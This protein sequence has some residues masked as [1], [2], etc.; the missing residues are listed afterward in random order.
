MY[1]SKLR[2]PRLSGSPSLLLYPEKIHAAVFSVRFVVEQ[3]LGRVSLERIGVLID[4][5]AGEIMLSGDKHAG[6]AIRCRDVWA[7][8]RQFFEAQRRRVL[9]NSNEYRNGNGRRDNCRRR[10]RAKR[11]DG[12]I[13]TAWV[14]SQRSREYTSEA[15]QTWSQCTDRCSPCSIPDEFAILGGRDERPLRNVRCACLG[16]GSGTRLCTIRRMR[17]FRCAVP[18]IINEEAT[19]RPM[20]VSHC[21]VLQCV[22]DEVNEASDLRRQVLAMRIGGEDYKISGVVFG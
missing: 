20:P 14:L 19:P 15:F 22:R 1:L 18:G 4:N 13:L 7:L 12:D 10:Q 8:D 9:C 3:Y 11:L 6:R 16:S 17:R 5:C 21:I 2:W